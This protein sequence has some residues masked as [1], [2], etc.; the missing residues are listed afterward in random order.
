MMVVLKSSFFAALVALAGC[1]F[2]GATGQPGEVDDSDGG[3]IG[4]NGDAGVDPTPDSA[5]AV[6]PGFTLIGASRYLISTDSLTWSNAEARC[7]SYANAHLATLVSA[8]EALLVVQTLQS[9]GSLWTGLEQRKKPRD[10]VGE[11]WVNIPS[12]M[13]MNG[14]IP[15]DGSEPND[16][17]GF[18]VENGEEDV[19]ELRPNGR[20]NDN[21]KQVANRALC[22]CDAPT[23]VR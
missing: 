16:G 15:W 6:C 21:R 18:Y 2:D 8:A 22:E 5:P 4:G 9:P 7:A 17:S 10:N 1:G 12:A 23:T 19:A 3:E 20:F 13:A 14:P 11:G